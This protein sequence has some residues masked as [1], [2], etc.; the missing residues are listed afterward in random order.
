MFYNQQF[1]A[2]LAAT[3]M[4]GSIV[5][6]D[7]GLL[8]QR[9]PPRSDN[10]NGNGYHVLTWFH[11]SRSNPSLALPQYSSRVPFAYGTT[12]GHIPL[13]TNF[14]THVQDQAL[15]DDETSSSAK[16]YIVSTTVDNKDLPL[17]SE[18]DREYV[19]LVHAIRNGIGNSERQYKPRLGSLQA[20]HFKTV[21]CKLLQGS[22]QANV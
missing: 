9:P 19:S 20:H 3:Q 18:D 21:L 11:P 7:S 16:V 12:E 2:G 22:R 13:D 15:K 1:S 6:E 8:Y 17:N 10:V 5:A 14:R 4:S